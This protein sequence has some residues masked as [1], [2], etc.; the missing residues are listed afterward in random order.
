G[1]TATT[2]TT[3]RSRFKKSAR[4]TLRELPRSSDHANRREVDKV[5]FIAA[6]GWA[7][8]T[9]KLI[10]PRQGA[11]S[12]GPMALGREFDGD[13]TLPDERDGYGMGANA[14]ARR[15]RGR[16]GGIGPHEPPIIHIC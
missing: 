1:R 3:S 13:G 9:R 16:R 10:G 11:P 12:P 14:L 5:R 6:R 15:S 2:A 4:S 8:P 7:A